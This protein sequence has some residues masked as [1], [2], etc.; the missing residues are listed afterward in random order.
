VRHQRGT[1]GGGGMEAVE[2]RACGWR[3]NDNAR[4]MV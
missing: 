3:Q 1:D 4:V 2:E